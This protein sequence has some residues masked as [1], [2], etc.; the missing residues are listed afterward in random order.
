LAARLPKQPGR[1]RRVAPIQGT[2]EQLILRSGQVS[3]IP[4]LPSG[5]E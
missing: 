5:S 1:F 4:A 2:N 3:G